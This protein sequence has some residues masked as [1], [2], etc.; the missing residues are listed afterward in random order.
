MRIRRIFLVVL[1]GVG[2]GASPD[3][4]RYGD[5]GSN[6]LVNT[7]AA[8]GGLSLPY[9]HRWGLGCLA[10]IPGVPPVDAPTAAHGI[11][12]ELSAGKDTTT[13]HWELAGLVLDKPFPTFP[14]G[15]PP[16]VID[17]FTAAIGRPVLGNK[18]AS[19]TE[20]L[21]ELGEKHLATGYPIV[22]TSADSVFQVA[23]HEE[24]VPREELYRWCRI[25]RE[26]LQG[27]YAVGRV[28][29]RPFTGRPGAFERTAGRKDFSLPP[30]EET[31]LDRLAAAGLEVIGLGKIED[32]FAGRG[33]TRSDHTPDNRTT[34]AALAA[35]VQE[36][37]TGLVFA[38]CVDFD[39]RYGHRNDPP[40]LAAALR[41][42][43]TAL[44][45]MA[46]RL[47]PE[48]LLI[49]T[50]DHGCD[51]TTASTDHSRED[52]PLLV[53][54]PAVRPGFLGLREGFTDVGATIIDLFGL[55]PWPRGRSF[56]REIGR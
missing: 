56:A 21:A 50:A 18:P 40:G 17:R 20:I 11:L 53:V 1:D 46:G 42:A 10:A 27:P 48:D 3:A 22:Y 9:F 55:G 14:H 37:F 12:R 2:I 32:I 34:L 35:L 5:A 52:V 30:P 4:D 19:G 33:L 41:E 24:I 39:T 7:A 29:A 43:D 51:P 23:A 26:I 54:G 15:F 44:G 8:V 25:A 47:G 13:G 49:I 6:T 36:E 45:E 38:N 31:V 28:I 16:E